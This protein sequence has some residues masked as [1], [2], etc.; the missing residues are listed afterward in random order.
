MSRAALQCTYLLRVLLV[1]GFQFCIVCGRV[2]VMHCCRQDSL[3]GHTRA[4][5]CASSAHCAIYAPALGSTDRTRFSCFFSC[6]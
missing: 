4:T 5:G 3:E 1:E 2:C 6:L